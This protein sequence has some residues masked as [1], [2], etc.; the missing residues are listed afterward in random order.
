[1]QEKMISVAKNQWRFQ[2]IVARWAKKIGLAGN[3]ARM[4]GYVS[5]V[6]VNTIDL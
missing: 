3:L 2:I 4:N 1:M 5:Y 6:Y